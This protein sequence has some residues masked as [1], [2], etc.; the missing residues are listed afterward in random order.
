LPVIRARLAD[1]FLKFAND[2]EFLALIGAS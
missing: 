2:E 1:Y